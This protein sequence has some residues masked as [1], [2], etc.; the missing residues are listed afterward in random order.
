[1]NITIETQPD[2]SYQ[3]KVRSDDAYAFQSAISSL[4]NCVDVSCREWQPAAKS[5]RIALD[6]QSAMMEWLDYCREYFG[7][8]VS[9]SSA[10]SERRDEWKRETR[11]PERD[12]FKELFLLPDAAAGCQ[13]GVSCAGRLASSRSWRRCS[14]HAAHQRGLLGSLSEAGG[15]NSAKQKQIAP[16]ERNEHLE[17]LLQERDANKTRYEMSHSLVEKK[18]AEAYEA[19]KAKHERHIS[20]G[21]E[22]TREGIRK[23]QRETK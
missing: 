17:A 20:S 22:H 3:I 23:W 5:W 9:W 11:Q 15:M 21:T 10:K 6:G 13:G 4:K 12:P 14:G 1:M 8:Q 7:A 16:F 18:S 19:A 2:R